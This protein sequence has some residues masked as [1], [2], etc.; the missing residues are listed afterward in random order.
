MKTLF[1]I[2]AAL[3][4]L[5]LALLWFVGS[6]IW[7]SAPTLNPPLDKPRPLS[8]AAA[9]G[10]QILF[11]DLHVH[12]SFSL[13][14][15]IFAT[16]AVKNT[17]YVSPADACDFA[18]YCSALDFW[19]INDHAESITP[20]QWQQT[21]QAVR[22]CNAVTSA[23]NP[24]LV[25]F[26]GW[27]WT[28][29]SASP[30]N[31]YGHKNVIFRD[32]ADDA[33]PLRPIASSSSAWRAMGTTAAPLR[34]AA[35]LGAS[36]LTGLSHYSSIAEHLRAMSRV[37]DCAD[38]DVRELP[39]DCYESTET[40][41]QLFDKLD[42]WGFDAL[43]IPH[44]LA[45]GITNPKGADFAAQMEQHDPRYQR[46][47]EVY[48]GHG[49]SEIYR[50]LAVTLAGQ[51]Q[52]PQ[53]ANGYTACCW[54]AGEIIRGR[55]EQ[56]AAGD[57][58]VKADAAQQNYLA[59]DTGSPL[60]APTEVVPDATVD[61][62]GQCDQLVDSFQPAYNYQPRNSAQY[63]LTLGD[64]NNRANPNRARMG[65]IGSS[66]NH[67][68]RAGSGY[69]EF[70]RHYMTD[71]KDKPAKPAAVVAE[72][73]AESIAAK[74]ISILAGLDAKDRSSAFYFSGGLV[75]VH[76]QGRDRQAI[77]DALQRREVYG[78]SGPRI[79]LWFDLVDRQGEL[80][81][82]GSELW[83]VGNP[84][85]RVRAQG[86]FVQQPGCPEHSAATMGAERIEHLCRGECYNPGDA[87]HGIERIEVVRILPQFPDRQDTAELIQ[88]PW[89][90]FDCEPGTE[91][92]EVEFEDR[93]FGSMG[94]EVV[95]YVRAV[96]QAT[97]TVNGDPFRCDY[98]AEGNCIK[99]NYCLGVAEEDDCLSDAAHRAWSSPIFVQFAGE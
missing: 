37:P 61:D 35:L 70:A 5:T 28:R 75:A 10:K 90:S 56:Q 65:F 89:R 66:D 50:D 32:T 97:A 87:R 63:I 7:A 86:S 19:S 23:D 20:Q 84:K 62:W 6:G 34:G 14:A 96:Q 94:R 71:T 12:T 24:D 78:P 83:S 2:I 92:C 54:Q 95:Y 9:P 60:S 55:C 42:Q 53:P 16:P 48:S 33:V 22:Q 13:D 81:P 74:E 36:K 64:N 18:R 11:G 45:W 59:A 41:R 51:E 91:F 44:G 29:D 58:D 46:F 4:L 15:A 77:W 8:V 31:H 80:H 1:Q 47:L 85:F 57:C 68:A 40:P 30:E 76:S 93:E 88:D 21:R 99:T 98:D 49:N 43:V 27:E 26:L 73:A 79:G 38:Q 17:G 82:M 39:V 72:P 69:K 3:L 67:T 52:C 25:S